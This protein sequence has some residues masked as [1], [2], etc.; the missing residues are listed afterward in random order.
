MDSRKESKKGIE[1]RKRKPVYAAGIDKGQ[2][3]RKVFKIEKWGFHLSNTLSIK[4]TVSFVFFFSFCLKGE[5]NN[6]LLHQSVDCA[7]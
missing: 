3:K 2:K 7:C 5:K 6:I 4:K 1:K